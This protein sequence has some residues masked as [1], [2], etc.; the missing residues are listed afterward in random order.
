[1]NAYIAH[2]LDHV[3]HFERDSRIAAEGGELPN[4]FQTMLAK[5][6]Q[7]HTGDSLCETGT[8]ETGDTEST[9][10]SINEQGRRRTKGRREQDE[11]AKARRVL[12]HTRLRDESAGTKKER[13]RLVKEEQ[14]LN[15]LSKTPKHIKK[16]HEKAGKKH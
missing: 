7:K 3:L 2:K 4:P 15:R 11:E 8:F 13:K 14:R 10:D 1:M 12:H 16:R 6:E 9:R 5:V